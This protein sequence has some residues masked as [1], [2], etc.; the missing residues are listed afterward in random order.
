MTDTFL[1]LK[2]ALMEHFLE[3]VCAMMNQIMLNVTLMEGIAV[4]VVSSQTIVQNAFVILRQH[5]P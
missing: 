2:D 5:Q 1:F 4:E 3:M